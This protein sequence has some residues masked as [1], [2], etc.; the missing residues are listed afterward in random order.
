MA[1]IYGLRTSA[2]LSRYPTTTPPT[3]PGHA[4]THIR[5]APSHSGPLMAAQ[6]QD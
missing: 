1:E 2:R 5:P 3:D 4:D 6:R